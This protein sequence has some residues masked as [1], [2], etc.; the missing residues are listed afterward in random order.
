MHGGLHGG[1]HACIMSP[2]RMVASSSTLVA[3]ES[4]SLWLCT[5]EVRRSAC[6]LA[7]STCAGCGPGVRVR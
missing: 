7:A 3:L 1:L 4:L 2:M 5:K 6:R